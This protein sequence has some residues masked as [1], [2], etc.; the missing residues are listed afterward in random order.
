[1]FV[2]V[3]MLKWAAGSES[4]PVREYDAFLLDVTQALR[5]MTT[6]THDE[7]VFLL[8]ARVMPLRLIGAY[9][10][11][12]RLILASVP[13]LPPLPLLNARSSEL[14]TTSLICLLLPI[15]RRA[16]TRVHSFI[17]LLSRLVAHM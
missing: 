5:S 7:Y 6:S 13:P 10:S 4:T 1:M 2:V 11:P 14:I 3:A 12:H 16:E 15:R 9:L 17:T 8:N